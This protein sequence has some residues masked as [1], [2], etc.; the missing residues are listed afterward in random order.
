MKEYRQNSH[1]FS[2]AFWAVLCSATAIVL[3]VHSHKIVSRVLRTEEILGGIALLI[4]GPAALA[5]YLIRARQMWVSVDFARGILVGGRRLIPWEEIRRIER[6]RPLLRRGSGPA[7]APDFDPTRAWEWSGGCIDA[8]CWMSLSEF[9]IAGLLLIAAFF[10]VWL[11]FFVLVPLLIIPVLEVFTP[12]GDRI[13]VVTRRGSL[14]LRDLRDAD[15][16]VRLVSER[17]PPILDS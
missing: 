5:V 11:V 4:F 2:L 7:Q 3:F 10:F 17:R 12:F 9:F 8:G 15:E 1:S 14:V 6:K 13:K 16:F